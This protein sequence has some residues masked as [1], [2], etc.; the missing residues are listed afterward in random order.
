M[1]PFHMR[2]ASIAAMKMTNAMIRSIRRVYHELFCSD[3]KK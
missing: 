1:G 2:E 3:T